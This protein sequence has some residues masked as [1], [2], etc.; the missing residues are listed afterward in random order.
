MDGYFC[1]IPAVVVASWRHKFYL[2]LA[3]VADVVL[4]VLQDFII[5]H[6]LLGVDTCTPEL[7]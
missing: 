5:H 6:M 1:C 2:E 4:H 7:L 3:A